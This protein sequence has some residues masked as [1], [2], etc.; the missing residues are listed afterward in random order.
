MAII[1]RKIG[2]DGDPVRGYVSFE[3]DYDDSKLWLRAVR[4]INN[5]TENA[6]GRAVCLTNARSGDLVFQPAQ[7]MQISIPGNAANGMGVTI[8]PNGKIDG[9]DYWFMWPYP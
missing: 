4:C 3:I 5:S 8:L 1:T 6:W 2:G 9:V 7:T